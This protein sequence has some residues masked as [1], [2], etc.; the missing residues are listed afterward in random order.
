MLLT[1]VPEEYKPAFH[2]EGVFHEIEALASR[3]L[4]VS[5]SKDK[6]K[7][8]DKETKDAISSGLPPSDLSSNAS[9]PPPIP[10]VSSSRKSSSNTLDPEDAVTLRARVIRFKFLTDDMAKAADG[11]MKALQ[12]LVE[13][14]SL[15]DASEGQITEALQALAG[16][17]ASS[18][19]SS[20]E[21]LQ[22]G[23]VDC[24]LS[25]AT[26]ETRQGMS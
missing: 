21:L 9:M 11:T 15:V 6:D 20:F 7:D 8:K 1:K 4:L 5:R 16:L 17:F 24:L 14:L 13:N 26:D 12:R 19:V 2:R 25:L 3:N 23:V 10:V 18:S 22:S